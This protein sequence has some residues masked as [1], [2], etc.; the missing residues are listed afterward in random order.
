M[1]QQELTMKKNEPIKNIMTKNVFSVNSTQKVSDVK[2]L[3]EKHKIHHVPVVS[4]KQ[5]IGLISAVDILKISFSQLYTQSDRFNEEQLDNTVKIT[6]IM[7]KDL[8]LIKESQSVRDAADI[9]EKAPFNS[10]PVINEKEELVGILTSKDL[11]KY[12]A[13]QF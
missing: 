8:K 1:A 13:S 11:I 9:L 7:T 10:L 4:N 5:I 2:N 3:M 12:L 6:E